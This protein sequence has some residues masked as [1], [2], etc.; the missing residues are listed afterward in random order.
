MI[1]TINITGIMI[2]NN[3]FILGDATKEILLNNTPWYQN[4]YNYDNPI[5]KW[6]VRGSNENKGIFSFTTLNDSI[7]DNLSTRITLK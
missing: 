4:T 5:D 7:N 6:I 1:I 3:S 2:A